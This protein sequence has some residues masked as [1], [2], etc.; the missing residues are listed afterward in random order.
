MEY[1]CCLRLW[2]QT[3]GQPAS[4]CS[5]RFSPSRGILDQENGVA[6]EGARFE[7]RVPEGSY[8]FTGI[9]CES[10]FLDIPMPDNAAVALV[11]DRKMVPVFFTARLYSTHDLVPC[12]L[13]RSSGSL[14]LSWG[15]AGAA[16]YGSGLLYELCSDGPG[17]FYPIRPPLPIRVTS[18]TVFYVV[19]LQYFCGKKGGGSGGVLCADASRGSVSIMKNYGGDSCRFPVFCGPEVHRQ[20][21]PHPLH[22]VRALPCDLFLNGE[23]SMCDPAVSS[24]RVY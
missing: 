17:H 19:K 11:K 24:L 22:G 7:L 10:F 9:P 18:L 13:R 23:L 4:S 3:A 12:R 16:Q 8:R 1:C 21:P 6:G 15:W 5:G 2:L 20:T 14:H